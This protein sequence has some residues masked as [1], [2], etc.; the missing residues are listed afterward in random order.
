LLEVRRRLISRLSTLDS[1]FDRHAIDGVRK[2]TERSA[3]QEGLVSALW[4]C[5]CAF[6]RDAVLASAQGTN[7]R[8]GISVT[9]PLASRSEQ[10]ICFVA[11]E[12]AFRRSVTT[13][14]PLAGRHLEPTWGDLGKLNLILSGIA[15]SN[16]SQLLSAFG[17][18]LALADLQTCRNA[19][20]RLNSDTIATVR[21]T[22]VRY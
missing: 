5:W 8:S 17:V 2:R 21:A 13:I 1:V 16:Q 7:T 10:E 14:R 20:A 18:A 12:L 11:R 22:R 9:S 15:F 4:Q 6:C 3:L 19:S